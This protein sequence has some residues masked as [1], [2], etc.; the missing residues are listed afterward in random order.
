MGD[1][2]DEPLGILFSDV[3]RLFWR[4]LET[5]WAAA[6]F[7]LGS[8]EVRV[9]MSVVERPGLRQAQ[10]A[11]SLH[12]EPMTLT[13]HLDRL[14]GRGLVER[15]PDPVDRRAKLVH[16][17]DTAAGVLEALR[18]ASAGVRAT[19]TAGFSAEEEMVLR[20]LLQRVRINLAK[21]AGGEGTR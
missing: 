12:I 11:E 14:V 1:P 18:A 3:A 5:A 21:V 2:N 16:P 7:D 19:Q 15:R 4:R 8:A 20:R 9:L 10:L 17:T 13:G 6:G